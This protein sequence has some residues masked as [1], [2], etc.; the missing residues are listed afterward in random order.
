MT[1]ATDRTPQ[2][3]VRKVDAGLYEFGWYVEPK[4]FRKNATVYTPAGTAASVA[5]AERQRS[6]LGGN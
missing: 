1:P 5:E 4:N 6:I 2:T 3:Y